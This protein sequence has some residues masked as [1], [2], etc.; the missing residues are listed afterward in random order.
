MDLKLDLK[1]LLSD[2]FTP[3]PSYWLHE[4]T[5]NWYPR[6]QPKFQQFL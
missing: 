2:F 3:H 1:I 5:N 6:E 4:L